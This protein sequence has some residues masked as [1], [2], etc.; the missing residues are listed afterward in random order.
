MMQ[1]VVAAAVVAAA[2]VVAEVAAAAVV[3][4]AVWLPLLALSLSLWAVVVAAVAT[5][6]LW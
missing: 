3:P 1:A 5:C 2:M 6:D 4:I